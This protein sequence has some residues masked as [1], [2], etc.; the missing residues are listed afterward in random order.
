MR[1]PKRNKKG[2]GKK[3]CK[4]EVVDKKDG[5]KERFSLKKISVL[6]ECKFLTLD[7]TGGQAKLRIGFD[8]DDVMIVVVVSMMMLVIYDDHDG[9]NNRGDDSI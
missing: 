6:V 1:S 8:D 9:G 2:R 7:Y 3:F 4:T 5:K